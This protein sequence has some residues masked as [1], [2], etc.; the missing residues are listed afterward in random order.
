MHDVIDSIGEHVP[1]KF[2]A[3]MP[4]PFVQPILTPTASASIGLNDVCHNSSFYTVPAEYYVP[5][6]SM[7]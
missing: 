1:A 4:I 5:N 7:Q 2:T 6:C 3:T